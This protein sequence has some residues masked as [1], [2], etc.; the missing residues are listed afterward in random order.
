M[1]ANMLTHDQLAVWEPWLTAIVGGLLL[2]IVAHGW[3]EEETPTPASRLMDFA[4]IA[5]G[6]GIMALGSHSDAAEHGLTDLRRAVVALGSFQPVLLT[7]Q[8]A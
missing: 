7:P 8:N 6:V 1:L 2:H 3:P 4:A 5:A